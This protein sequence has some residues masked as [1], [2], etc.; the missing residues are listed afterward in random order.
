MSVTSASPTAAVD[1]KGSLKLTREWVN[2]RP[3]DLADLI[4]SSCP[5]MLSMAP[6]VEWKS[7][8]AADAYH[9]YYDAE[10]LHKV[11][12]TGPRYASA[13]SAFWPDRGPHWDALAILRGREGRGVLLVE[14]KSYPGEMGSTCRAS[15]ASEPMIERAL[16]RTRGY[17]GV[18]APLHA[19]MDGAYQL[20]NRLAHHHFPNQVAGVPAFLALVSLVG[21]GSLDKPTSIGEW[22]AHYQ[23][24]FGHLGL[25]AGSRLL[26][27]VALVYPPA[28][29]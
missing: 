9:E 13:L 15:G 26:N 20:A 27:R 25:H 22:R 29:P 28:A 3:D 8:L 19:W 1:A 14:A 24:P 12:L 6:T 21:D 11:G 2:H 5:A 7:P 18:T 4:V 16:E 10:F 23:G 17:R